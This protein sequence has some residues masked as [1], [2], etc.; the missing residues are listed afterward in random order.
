MPRR[1]PTPSYLEHK[2]SGRARAVWSDARGRHDRLLPGLFGSAES[3]TAYSRLLAELA[4]SVA[5]VVARPGLSINELLLAYVRHAERHYRAPDGGSTAEIGHIKVITRHVRAL[6]GPTPAVDFGPLALRAV[7]ERFV[8]AGWCRKTVNHQV[9]RLR[10]AFKWAAAEELIG[11]DVYSRLTVV[12][13]LQKG[14]TAAPEP[15]PVGPVE[16][17]TVDATLPFLNRHAR[18]LIQF[19][20]L[21]GCRPGEAC[22]VR[23]CDLDTTA[24]VW[25]YRPATHKGSWR[26]KPRTIAV[27]PKAQ[28]LLKEFSV[29]DPAAFVFSPRL[30]MAEVRAV[31]AAER[32]TPR[33][34]SHER[35]NLAKRKPRPRRAPADRYTARALF[36]AVARAVELA[37]RAGVEV[38]HWHPNQL[39][40]SFAT[41]VRREHGLEAAQVSLG[42]ARA[43]VTQVYAERNQELAAAVARKAG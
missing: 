41:R 7:R 42:H 27:G 8:A 39:R 43:D 36:T 31:R 24:D 35:R 16:N 21:T 13:G 28:A 5:P 2:L 20:R 30:A 9:E 17:A 22:A 15:E 4:V 25:L 10:R 3:R 37:N 40:H 14:R 18:G 6:Y 32:K 38:P 33:W 12:S 11:F 19:Q 1:N 23:R 29:D 34:P 26:G